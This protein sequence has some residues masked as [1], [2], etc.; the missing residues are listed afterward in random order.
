MI[1]HHKQELIYLKW[2]D[3]YEDGD[4]KS[5]QQIED[6]IKGEDCICEDAGWV[7]YE[8]EKVLCLCSRRL[9]W[10]DV[11]PKDNEDKYGLI[12]KIPKTW[13]VERKLLKKT[14]G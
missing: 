10:T 4:W 14:R 2:L 9:T 1:E 12:Q 6:L 7:L 5:K 8:D 13:I 11:E 3:A